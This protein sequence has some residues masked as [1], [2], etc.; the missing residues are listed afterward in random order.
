MEGVQVCQARDKHKPMK[1]EDAPVHVKKNLKI[2]LLKS[3]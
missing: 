3:T 2:S 1:E